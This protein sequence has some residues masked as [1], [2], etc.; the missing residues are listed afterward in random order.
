MSRR[1]VI[2][3]ASYLERAQW[4]IW[5]TTAALVP[6]SYVQGIQRGGGCAVILPP[7]GA[8]AGVLDRLD[9]LVLPAGADLDPALYGAEAHPCGEPP[10]AERDVAELA[11]LRAAL[12]VDL[13]VL[14]VCRG[15]Q[16]LAV[17]YGG[18]LHQHLPD[19]LGHTRHC[20]RTGT[21]G[22]HEVK[23][24]EGSALAG[25]LGAAAVVNSHHHQAVADPG[26]LT[27]TGFSDD[28]V[29]EAV[30]DP[31]KPFVVGVQ[32]HPELLGD[33][34]LFA[35]LVRAAATYRAKLSEV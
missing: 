1:P 4:N 17:A 5:D 16:L 18:N 21:M 2:G 9:G 19:L 27:V 22:S 15:I 35:A 14:G 31:G 34:R 3:I 24:A 23:F 6:H 32:W 28:G 33:D 20:P 29:A 11:L 26:G 25:L 7:D 12:A 30:E 13:P 10:H 8:D